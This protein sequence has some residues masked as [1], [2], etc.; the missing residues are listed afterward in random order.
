MPKHA[1]KLG[2]IETSLDNAVIIHAVVCGARRGKKYII[3]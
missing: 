1:A 3:T 2:S